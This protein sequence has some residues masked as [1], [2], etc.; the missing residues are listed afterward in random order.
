MSGKT[1]IYVTYPTNFRQK[2]YANYIPDVFPP[3]IIM[4]SET[5][6]HINFVISQILARWTNFDQGSLIVFITVLFYL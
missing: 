5:K 2:T 1:L 6:G 4:V 3:Y